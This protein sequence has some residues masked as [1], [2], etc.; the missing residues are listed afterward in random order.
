MKLSPVTLLRLLLFVV[1]PLLGGTSW[2]SQFTWN[3]LVGSGGSGTAEVVAIRAPRQ[4][5][6]APPA[7]AAVNMKGAVDLAG[8]PLLDSLTAPTAAVLRYSD[9]ASGKRTKLDWS[10]TIRSTGGVRITGL[11]TAGPSGE[12]FVC[13]VSEGPPVFG[14]LV[15]PIGP[16][17]PRGFVA[18]LDPAAGVWLGYFITEGI[19]PT[20]VSFGANQ[21]FVTGG[22][23]LCAAYSAG[24][25]PRWMA[26]LPA[27][28]MAASHI[29]LG[30]G[31]IQVLAKSAEGD[32]SL[33][34]SRLSPLD[35]ST[36]QSFAVEGSAACKAA[37]LRVGSDGAVWVAANRAPGRNPVRGFLTRLRRDGT[38]EWKSDLGTPETI[39]DMVV[40]SFDL[41]AEGNAW[42]G[43]KLNGRWAFPDLDAQD[44]VQ[45]VALVAV[46]QA[47][48]VFDF[49]RGTGEGKESATA[50]CAAVPGMAMLGGSCSGGLLSLGGLSPLTPGS[51]GSMFLSSVRKAAG[52]SHWVFRNDPASPHLLD[53][54][55][56]R[57][58]LRA[59]GISPYVDVNNGL[60]GSAVTGYATKEQI[61]LLR[62]IGGVVAEPEIEIEP[63]LA[64]RGWA[65]ARMA[66]ASNKALPQD[67]VDYEPVAS[68]KGVRLYLID[69]AV[70]HVA[71]WFAANDKLTNDGTVLIRGSGDPTVS[72]QFEHGT[73]MLS[74][75]AGPET[76]AVTRT[77][78]RM[79]NLDIY[80]KGNST[81]GLLAN[82]ILEA[83]DHHE[84]N[85]PSQPAT[86]C[87]ASSSTASADSTIVRM[88]LQKAV[89]A[90]IVVIVSAGNDGKSASTYLPARYG[91]MDGV[92]CVG[93]SGTANERAT[94]SNYGPAVDVYAPG[95]S[96]R[97]LRYADPQKGTYDLIN[98]TSASAAY[99]SGAALLQLSLDP[100][101]SPGAVEAALKSRAYKGPV[102]LLQLAKPVAAVSK[103]A[104][105]PEDYDGDGD[106]FV[107]L[108]ERFHGSSVTDA[109]SRPVP[110]TLRPEGNSVAAR[111]TIASDLFV[112]SNPYQL[113]DGTR[114]KVMVSE[115]LKTW[116]V[117]EGTLT[118]SAGS[119]GT[120]E[121]K[122]VFAKSGE[123]GFVK[124]E[125]VPAE[126]V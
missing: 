46:D 2:G 116:R 117:A 103:E 118:T 11:A 73:R 50:V 113:S 123:R 42:V 22:G 90:G 31:G 38:T 44:F 109:A 91:T 3:S 19:L 72:S 9:D 52:L 40:G 4:A 53:L 84:E 43:A 95:D 8:L 35:G 101:L 99:A 24:G 66:D 45:D 32:G 55:V 65:L 85:E 29:D 10:A 82:A 14:G 67:K 105:M 94:F 68:T 93:A 57:H 96:V 100:G 16:R 37:G 36:L 98:G 119:S 104:S 97:S 120:M 108:I 76:G 78:V 125:V 56:L 13:G 111:F 107:D 121:V 39:A 80:P 126:E 83:V 41:D 48:K 112:S 26:S 17:D 88:A 6:E 51:G 1:L 62:A 59:L 74:L 60:L 64:D 47:G 12:I 79:L 28:S 70:K 114:W 75:I 61:A 87:L 71:N 115:D 18:R 7:F 92:I 86:I 89:D 69:T 34:V 21:V 63:K 106:G 5:G 58:L 23:C 15:L 33:K 20:G 102:T 81:S 49:Q 124:I 25:M 110:I 77:P 30:P 122:F 27:G 54:P